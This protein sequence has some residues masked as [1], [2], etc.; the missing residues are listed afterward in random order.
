M[1]R[2]EA[3]TY[4]QAP[5]SPNPSGI[6]AARRLS[7]HSIQPFASAS[8]S[9]SLLRGTP[10]QPLSG[11]PIPT[12][13][14]RPT[15]P[16]S[17]TSSSIGRTSS[18]LSQ[19]GRSFTHAQLA[20]MYGGSASPPVTGAMS[21]VHLPS[22]PSQYNPPGQSP[23]SQS[24]LTFAKQPVPRNVSMSSRG[25]GSTPGSGS[26][27][28][29][30]GSLER[31]ITTGTG[32][33]G[34]SAPNPPHI[35]KRYSSSF[36]S[37]PSSLTHRPSL[38]SQGSS[39]E[40]SLPSFLGGQGG[41][42]R[43]TST[44]E[45]GLR[46]SL[47]PPKRRDGVPDEDDIEAFLKTLDAVPQPSRSQ[48]AP[49]G[50]F[51][52]MASSLST[53]EHRAE[54]EGTPNSQLAISPQTQG[55]GYNGRVPMTRAWVDDELKRMAGSFSTGEMAIPSRGDT[56]ASSSS[57]VNTAASSARATMAG[58]P[59]SIGLLSASRPSSASRR[60]P[61]TDAGTEAGGQ[62]VI[63]RKSDGP[64]P[65]S[66][67]LTSAAERDSSPIAASPMQ[68]LRSADQVPADRGVRSTLSDSPAATGS[69]RSLPR[70]AMG[71]THEHPEPLPLRSAGAGVGYAGLSNY[72][73]TVVSRTS[74]LSPQT[75][76][77]TNSTDSPSTSVTTN[78][79][80]TTAATTRMPRR[81]P[82]LL[83]GGFEHRSSATSTPSHSPVR[84]Y[85]RAGVAVNA[86][87]TSGAIG[88]GI[89][90]REAGVGS[91]PIRQVG[92]ERERYTELGRRQS[93]SIAMIHALN[94]SGA[95]PTTGTIGRYRSSSGTAPGSLGREEYGK[96][97]GR[98]GIE[99]RT[100]SEG[101]EHGRENRAEEGDDVADDELAGLM[102]G[103]GYEK[104]D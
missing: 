63:R 1:A 81:G 62:K 104:R 98:E 60:V 50:R 51:A 74:V 20:N 84:D 42:L 43:R 6:V 4:L 34:T 12:S 31:D 53:R 16:A 47:E 28:F 18:F 24:S 27:P 32:I 100:E 102:N 79:T 22:T 56:T 103:L 40:A 57:N 33:T 15:I 96:R 25:M 70:S 14:T 46:H 91:M 10:P 37:R 64:S 39:A 13:S 82:V 92:D 85:A 45:S 30:P 95:A 26:S 23:V 68:A 7:G 73:A 61:I 29:I 67:G 65:L 55:Q 21:G 38:Q 75:T 101:R 44:R 76:G 87:S 19:S 59:A 97:E 80:S 54:G 69:A 86:A 89:S 77:G 71:V 49:S 17:R 88:L 36:S 52:S 3:N 99:R 93:A 8:P 66:Q 9:T 83:R 58:T 90:T 72:G 5:P 2:K 78:A 41:L 48:Y 11:A 35:I 94:A